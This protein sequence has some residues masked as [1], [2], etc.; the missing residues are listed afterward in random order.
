MIKFSRRTSYGLRAMRRLAEA[1][2]QGKSA[3]IH[4]LAE[5]E[6]VPPK[7]LE[8]VLLELRRAGFVDSKPGPGGG[9]RLARP[10]DEITVGDIVRA[11]EGGI[12]P[13]E[14]VE[15]GVVDVDC[16]GCPGLSRCALREVWLR[17]RE[18]AEQVLDQVSLQ[19]LV[20]R[21]QR[22]LVEAEGMYQI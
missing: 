8:Q 11:L 4:A 19:D 15:D 3:T 13:A 17:F 22:L 21:Q 9:Y 6:Q 18:A 12:G 7:Y 20:V 10:A 5:A 2:N 16:P 14:C 1:V